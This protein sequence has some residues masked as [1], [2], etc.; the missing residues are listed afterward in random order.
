MNNFYFKVSKQAINLAIKVLA[1]QI[2]GID[3]SSYNIEFEEH[4]NKEI[5]EIKEY[6]KENKVIC[7]LEV[8]QCEQTKVTAQTREIFLLVQGNGNVEYDYIKSALQETC[9]CIKKYCGGEIINL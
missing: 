3:N 9:E 7:R 1:V 8:I 4:K 6:W 2:I 5:E